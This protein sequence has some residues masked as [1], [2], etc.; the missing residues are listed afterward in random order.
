MENYTSIHLYY[1]HY[2]E[3]Y[4]CTLELYMPI[5]YMHAYIHLEHTSLHIYKYRNGYLC[6][7]FKDMA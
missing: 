3:V 5:K 7:Q 2:H 6:S 4:T 1:I